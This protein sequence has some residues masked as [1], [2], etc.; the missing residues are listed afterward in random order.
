MLK[1]FATFVVDE[2]FIIENT[3]LPIRLKMIGQLRPGNVTSKVQQYKEL[4]QSKTTIKHRLSLRS[5][6]NELLSS[7]TLPEMCKFVDEEYNLSELLESEFEWSSKKELFVRELY[8]KIMTRYT[9]PPI[10]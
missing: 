5:D 8:E 4:L 7:L 10:K 6:I 1:L 3:L 9:T 2:R